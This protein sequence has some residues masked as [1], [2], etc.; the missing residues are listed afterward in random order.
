MKGSTGS[1]VRAHP[2]AADAVMSI[3]F[4][5]EEF[6]AAWKELDEPQLEG[7]WELFT[8]TQ[9]VA[10]YRRYR[11]VPARNRPARLTPRPERFGFH[12]NVTKSPAFFSVFTS[13]D[14]FSRFVWSE[15]HWPSG[16]HRQEPGNE[17]T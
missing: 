15:P 17:R 10:I 9:G 1:A 12:G 13:L 16:P 2:V 11:Q 4:R 3:R 8:E 5:E 14:D 7:G 6:Q